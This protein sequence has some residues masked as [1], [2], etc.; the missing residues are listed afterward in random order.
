M[1][2]TLTYYTSGILS[3]TESVRNVTASC[4]G[5]GGD[6]NSNGT[7]GSGAAYAAKSFTVQSGSYTINV[8]QANADGLGN[9][10]VSNFISA[11]I[12]I[13]QAAGG[14]SDGT[15]T[16][17]STFNTGSTKYTGGTGGTFS[18]T[19]GNYGG[20]GGGSAAGGLGNGI[21][22][23]NGSDTGA[24]FAQFGH[25]LTGSLGASGADAGGG[26]GGNAAY[27]DAGPCSRL[28]S[29]ANGD[30]PGGGGGGGYSG[31]SSVSVKTEGTGG[32]G[33]VTITW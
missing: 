22:A 12:I 2:T 27:Y 7:G 5:A 4:W 11:S 33:M 30:L 28:I 1:A 14:R 9:G 25:S 21:A 26:N 19:Y 23:G 17:Q 20:A 29:A 24:S 13:V 16:G 18:G 3:V 6:G 10:G 8:G 15:I 32:A 31:E